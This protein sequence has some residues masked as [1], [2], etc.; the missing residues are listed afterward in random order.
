LR[1]PIRFGYKTG[2]VFIL[3]CRCVRSLINLDRVSRAHQQV[4][5]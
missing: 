1:V 4:E 2:Q 5:Q 3:S